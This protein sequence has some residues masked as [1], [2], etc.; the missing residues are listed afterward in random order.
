MRPVRCPS[1]LIGWRLI[2]RD[3]S[4][5]WNGKEGI[6]M[7]CRRIKK[8]SDGSG[9]SSGID[10][11]SGDN[12]DEVVYTDE[13]Y[14]RIKHQHLWIDMWN[15]LFELISKVMYDGVM[16]INGKKKRK[17]KESINVDVEK[18]SDS[19]RKIGSCNTSGN[20]EGTI[21]RLSDQNKN[22]DD[23]V[24]VDSTVVD[25]V[26]HGD[27]D[28]SDDRFVCGWISHQD[29]TYHM[30][31]VCNNREVL[32]DQKY[33]GSSN[34]SGNGN[35]NTNNVHGSDIKLITNNYNDSNN[36]MNGSSNDASNSNSNDAV[37]HNVLSQRTSYNKAEQ[38]AGVRSTMHKDQSVAASKYCE[39]CCMEMKH[40]FSKMDYE[41]IHNDSNE[42]AFI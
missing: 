27:N 39:Y 2:I 4:S 28:D 7:K 37:I 3:S 10:A 31:Y 40:D 26:V 22:G 20:I 17:K 35:N 41:V 14:V 23:L 25:Y 36:V 15:G 6:V 29:I 38:I 19:N 16:K 9:D 21:N 5:A 34:V 1:N 13:L 30:C 18:D 42:S 8:N 11:G 24:D 12:S 33:I 32:L